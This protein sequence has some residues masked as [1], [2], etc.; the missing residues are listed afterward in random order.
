VR[1]LALLCRGPEC[2]GRGCIVSSDP[3][4]EYYP[5]GYGEWVDTAP[6]GSWIV[7]PR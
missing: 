2:T 5:Q 1:T 7:C 3:V 4:S 6:D